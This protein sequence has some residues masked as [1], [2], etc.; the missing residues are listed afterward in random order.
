M[1]IEKTGK[2]FR[3]CTLRKRPYIMS[4]V[5]D[6]NKVVLETGKAKYRRGPNIGVYYLKG[7]I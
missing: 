4:I 1:K 6:K 7:N 2:S 3:L 5:I